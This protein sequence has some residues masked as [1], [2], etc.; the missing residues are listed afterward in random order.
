MAKPKYSMHDQLIHAKYL[1]VDRITALSAL[2][3]SDELDELTKEHHRK[4]ATLHF[5]QSV[6]Q[7]LDTREGARLYKKMNPAPVGTTRT[8]RAKII[9]L[10]QARFFLERVL[11]G[12]ADDVGH[13]SLV[14]FA[15]RRLVDSDPADASIRRAAA[16]YFDS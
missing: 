8:V 5:S 9:L 7:V 6:A 15:L 11:P 4:N 10:E 14:N 3:A 2:L 12:R 16:D 1:K 13:S